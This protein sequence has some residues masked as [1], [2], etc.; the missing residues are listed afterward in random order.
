MAPLNTLERLELRVEALQEEVRAAS[1]SNGRDEHSACVFGEF[2]HGVQAARP[3][4]M[5]SIR[6][7]SH[8]PD[9]LG[10]WYPGTEMPRQLR[11]NLYVGQL[12]Y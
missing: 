11:L 8:I 10:L 6:E 5:T 12:I 7:L 3:S 9:G 1:M 2:S 4:P